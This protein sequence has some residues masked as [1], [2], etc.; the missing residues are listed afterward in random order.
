[1]VPGEY[2]KPSY[3]NIS[4][5]GFVWEAIEVDHSVNEMKFQVNFTD[6][7][8][9]SSDIVQDEMEIKFRNPNL[10]KS[11][12]FDTRISYTSKTLISPVKK[13]MPN[14]DQ[15]RSF[16]KSTTQTTEGMNAVTIFTFCLNILFQGAM[17]EIL[18]TILS[19]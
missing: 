9:I 19:I 2:E 12:E 3:F 8:Y 10:F 7:V 17:K 5:L 4:K 6:A 16:D 15:S 1:M 11:V 14:N 13:Q 18:G